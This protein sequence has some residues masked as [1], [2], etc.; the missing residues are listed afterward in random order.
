MWQVNQFEGQMQRTPIWVSTKVSSSYYGYKSSSTF[1]I[2][3]PWSSSNHIGTTEQV[4]M[5]GFMGITFLLITNI[6]LQSLR[7]QLDGMVE[8]MNWWMWL[9]AKWQ[10]STIQSFKNKTDESNKQIYSEHTT[11]ISNNHEVINNVCIFLFGYKAKI[12][13][14]KTNTFVIW[15]I[16]LAHVYSQMCNI[17]QQKSYYFWFINLSRGWHAH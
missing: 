14:L 11:R 7:Q 15:F 9:L 17:F 5:H 3:G 16:C 1:R 12:M 4:Y 6:I 13:C 2:K 8:N 10:Q